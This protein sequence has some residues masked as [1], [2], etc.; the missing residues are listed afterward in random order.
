ME[1]FLKFFD[2][3]ADQNGFNLEIYYS[4][5]VDWC[6]TVGYKSTSKNHGEKVISI[7]ECEPEL[8]FAKVTFGREK[9]EVL[10]AKLCRRYSTF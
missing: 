9:N 7:Q 6:I 2:S 1:A 8:A 5:I 4:S 10:Y 3:I